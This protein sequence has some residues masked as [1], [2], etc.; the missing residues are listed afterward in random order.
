M[1]ATAKQVWCLLSQYKRSWA[2]TAACSARRHEWC[3]PRHQQ[4]ASFANSSRRQQ[5]V[6][7]KCSSCKEVTQQMA[8]ASLASSLEAL[9]S[10][11]WSSRVRFWKGYK[12]FEGR[13]TPQECAKYLYVCMYSCCTHG[14]CAC[15]SCLHSPAAPPNHLLA[16]TQCSTDAGES[17]V[18]CNQQPWNCPVMLYDVSCC[19]AVASSNA[20]GT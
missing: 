9:Q 3:C 17:E 10:H 1:S 11:F 5:R 19:I 15:L 8:P 16:L 2:A 4:G 20:C 13:D 18:A 6:H 14:F 12:I 7:T